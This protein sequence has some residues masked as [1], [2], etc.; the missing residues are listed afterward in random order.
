MPSVVPV[1][2]T[3]TTTITSFE[4]DSIEVRLFS[5]AI[6]RVN[7]FAGSYRT[8]I[9]SITLEGDDY[10]NW[11]NDDHYIN[12]YIAGVLGLTLVEPEAIPGVVEPA[13][14][15]PALVEPAVVEPAVVEPAVVE[16]AVVVEPEPVV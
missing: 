2:M 11:G 1:D 7:V 14:V 6:I 13:V 3:T 16:P 12:A 4:I 8:E 5:S 9:R 10:I 15:E